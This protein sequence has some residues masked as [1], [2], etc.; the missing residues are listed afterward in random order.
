[1]PWTLSPQ[2]IRKLVPT[3]HTN[4]GGNWLY[5]RSTQC[6]QLWGK[7]NGIDP[8]LHRNQKRLKA[9]QIRKGKELPVYELSR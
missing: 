4:Q 7:V 2:L 5:R 6:N 9:R 8:F 3:T 1:M